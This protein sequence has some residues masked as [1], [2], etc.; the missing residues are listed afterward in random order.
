[1]I[2]VVVIFL[3]AP[4]ASNEAERRGIVVAIVLN[5]KSRTQGE[6]IAVRP[7]AILLQDDDD[8]IMFINVGNIKYIEKPRKSPLIGAISGVLKY[9]FIGSIVGDLATATDANKNLLGRGTLLGGVAG[10][11]FGGVMGG[12]QGSPTDAID[13]IYI[14]G[15]PPE[16]VKSALLKL[17]RDARI[18]GWI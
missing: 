17:S 3:L 16:L 2:L 5:D 12:I 7:D 1:V 8:H 18:R 14:K 4:C 11:L 15:Y 13:T 10:I 9:G 6:L